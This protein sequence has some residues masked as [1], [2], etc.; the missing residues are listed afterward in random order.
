MATRDPLHNAPPE[1]EHELPDML[2]DRL[3]AGIFGLGSVFDITGASALRGI[4]RLLERSS[5]HAL[6]GDAE[7]LR[8]DGLRVRS[9]VELADRESERTFSLWDVDELD[10]GAVPRQVEVRICR[11]SRPKKYA[12]LYDYQSDLSAFSSDR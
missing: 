4:E 3:K 1:F 10:E 2:Q 9:R 11:Y 8:R 12:K 5:R 6:M 7:R